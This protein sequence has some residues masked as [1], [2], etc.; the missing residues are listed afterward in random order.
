[1]NMTP[2]ERVWMLR[3]L[4]PLKGCRIEHVSLSDDGFPTL[5]AVKK[6]RGK[7][8]ERFTLE[9]SRDEEGNGPG[10]LFGLPRPE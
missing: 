5:R 8:A 6:P 7:P 3:Y 4:Q 2:E 1:M 9:V 10:F